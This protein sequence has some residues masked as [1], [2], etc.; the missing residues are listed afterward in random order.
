M[1]SRYLKL[2]YYLLMKPLKLGSG[3]L[4]L[5]VE[6]TDACNQKCVM[7]YRDRLIDKPKRMS[8]EQFKAVLDDVKPSKVNISGLGEPML[9]KDIF[10]MVRYAKS[11]GMGVTFPTNLTLASR[12]VEEIVES[13]IDVIKASLDAANSETYRKVRGTDHFDAVM[14]AIR[15][16]NAL[17]E[18]RNLSAPHIRINYA[19][20][21]SNLDELVD[22]MRMAVELKA[23]AMYIQYLDYVDVVD[24]KDDL[25]GDMD[26]DHLRSVLIT[27]QEMAKKSGIETNISIWLRDLELYKSKMLSMG[28]EMSL[29]RKCLFPWLSTF[30]EANGD[31][32]A[33]PIFTRKRHE[34]NMG[35]IFEQPFKSIWNGELYMDIRR[36]L[37]AGERPYT[38]CR[39]CVPQ[40]LSNIFVIFSKMMPGWK[41]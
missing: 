3:P 14:E 16:I 1:D 2:P 26:F 13:G 5:Q 38:P 24:L 18:K 34:G 7:C 10:H 31:V 27:T 19:L 30:I 20:Q 32:K 40:S 23:E 35:N 29:T 15:G 36:K 41:P 39:Q 25:I 28:G 37:R 22:M 17:K 8:L 12:H 33:C 6:P 9:H 4:H 21:K 11:K